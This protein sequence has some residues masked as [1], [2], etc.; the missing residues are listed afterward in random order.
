M[1]RRTAA[2]VESAGGTGNGS[3][4]RTGHYD[5]P[6]EPLRVIGYA[7]CSTGDQVNGYSLGAQRELMEKWC[8]DHGAELVTVFID[9]MS[10]RRVERLVGREAAIAAV[11][12]FNDAATEKE[13]ETA[14]LVRRLDRASRSVIDGALFIQRARD[15]GWRLLGVDGTDSA[16]EDQDLAIGAKL[17]VAQEERRLISSRTKEGLARAKA[18]NR[19]PGPKPRVPGHIAERIREERE[20]GQTFREI[21][22]GLDADGIPTPGEAKK[23]RADTV[24]GVYRRVTERSGS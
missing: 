13:P 20:A 10:S 18:N 6:R 2:G 11:E 24:E 23:W 12:A 15:N 5:G 4:T 19:Y 21:A 22:R 7:R 1:P 8:A 9:V 14:L 3:R 17:L 16:D